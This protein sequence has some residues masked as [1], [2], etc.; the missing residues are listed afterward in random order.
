SGSAVSVALGLASF[1]L[2]TDTAGSGRV[3]ACFNN[4]VGLKPSIGLLPAT[5]MLPACRSL[6]CMTIFANDCDDAEQVLAVAE[7]VD[8]ADPYSRRNPYANQSRHYGEQT[9]ALMV[10]VIP[11]SQLKFFDDAPYAAAYDA[12]L[13]LVQGMDVTLLE[14]DY[15]PFDE[16]ARLLYEGPWVAER[17]IATRALITTEP[18]AM[19]PVVR[20]IIL[21]GGAT[22]A[23]ALFEAQYRLSALRKRCL[24]QLD[25]IDCLLTPTAGRCFTIEDMLAQPVERNS[26]LGYYTNFMNLLDLAAV[27]VPTGMASNGLPFG[28]TLAAAAFRD[29][30]LLSIARRIHRLSGQPTGATG[31]PVSYTPADT[32]AAPHRIDVL[33]CGAH[34]QGLPLNWQ[35][36]ERGATL[37]R[38]VQTAAIYRLYALAGGPPLRPGLVLDAD[39]GNAIE[40]ELWSMP[41]AE[42]GSFVAE[43]PAPL[44]I[45]KVVLEDGSSV[46][47]FICEPH[48]LEGA[49]EVTHHG[50]WRGYLQHLA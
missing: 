7:G 24:Q 13:E 43:I 34:L 50:S 37:Q 11:E 48:G 49:R 20:D 3:P 2:G 23:T 27:A 8:E 45:G 40:A 18:A 9:G 15:T 6:D 38:R 22:K 28:V 4:L 30:Y 29:R 12:A 35:L 19:F 32:V 10:G 26:Q 21:P 14:I 16:V 5:G 36:T 44:G 42:F 47:G 39:S 33:V 17:Y 31:H 1:S 46:A 41:A 25:R